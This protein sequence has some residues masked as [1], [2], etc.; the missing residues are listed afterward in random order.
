MVLK[1]LGSLRVLVFLYSFSR[2]LV[3]D[4]VAYNN[5]VLVS[6]SSGGQKSETRVSAG[7]HFL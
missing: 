7:L 5:R 2:A 4:W 3:T 6:H 1:E